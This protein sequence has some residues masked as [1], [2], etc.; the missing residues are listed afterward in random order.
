MRLSL[1]ALAATSL[2]SCRE[3]A[4]GESSAPR[5]VAAPVVIAPSAEDAATPR[6][7]LPDV[8]A[9]WCI[10]GWRG[11]D[12]GTCYLLPEVTDATRPKVLLIYL[13]GIMPPATRSPQKE[14]VL[15][16]VAG[17]AR[18]RGAIALVPRGRRGIG[19]ADAKDWWAWPTSSRDFATYASVMLGEWTSARAKLEAA[20]GPFE[21]VY[22]AGSS[23]GAYFVT[24]LVFAGAIEMD[25]YAAIS[26]GAAGYT[27]DDPGIKKR[28][29]YVGYA[30]G[31]STNAGPKGL[32]AFLGSAGWPVRVAAHPGGHGAREV[33]LDE[34]FAFW[35]AEQ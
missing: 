2:A 9:E 19:P 14:N 35:N 8:K 34:A 4:S 13:P 3:S 30:S 5:P 1:V 27:R 31:D 24:A 11:L 25:G 28:P 16:V 26:G 29:F 21:R 7:A 20:L 22:L 17:A 32:G 6:P 23:S 18:R 15:R 12:E 10:D 33:Y